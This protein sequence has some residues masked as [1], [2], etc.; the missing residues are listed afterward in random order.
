MS[1]GTNIKDLI[2]HLSLSAFIFRGLM[3]RT[4]K[5]NWRRL[6]LKLFGVTLEV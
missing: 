1:V 6:P 2:K 3:G 5:N 4:P